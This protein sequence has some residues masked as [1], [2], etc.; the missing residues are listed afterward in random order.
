MEKVFEIYIRTTPERL[1][2]AITDP[3]I[4]EQVQL[5]RRGHLGLDAGSR[6]EMATSAADVLLGEGENLEVDPPRRLVQTMTALWSDEVKGE[7]PSR[8]TWEITQV[9]DS[10]RLTVTHDQ[11][12]EGANEQ[13]YG[14]WPMILSGLKTWL[15]TGELLTTPG[16]LMY[17]E[18]SRTGRATA[19]GRGLTFGSMSPAVVHVA[20][21]PDDEA[22]GSPG[23]LL[24][25]KDR[26]WR[27]VSVF[28]SLGLP[29]Q[30][31]RRRAEAEE[32]SRRAGFEPV[33]LDPP[34]RIS[35]HDDL[36]T[37][38]GPRGGRAAPDRRRPRRN[39]RRVTLSPRG[40]P[41]PRN[42][43]PGRA[44]GHG[45]AAPV[46]PLVDVGRV[47]R[48]PRTQRLLPLRRAR[49][50]SHAAHPGG[51][52]RRARAQRLPA[53]AHRSVRLQCGA[54]I[55]TRLR[56]RVA[57]RQRPPLR[58]GAH[59]GAPRRRPLDGLRSRTSSTRAR[60]PRN[61]S[62]SDLTAWI[63]SPSAARL[64]VS[65]GEVPRGPTPEGSGVPT[66]AGGGGVPAAGCRR[67]A[68]PGRDGGNADPRAAGDGAVPGSRSWTDHRG[69]RVTEGVVTS[70]SPMRR[71]AYSRVSGSAIPGRKILARWLFSTVG[72][73]AP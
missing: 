22:L 53:T 42:G 44:T 58:R 60:C 4:T 20:P 51:L 35:R 3:E 16:S 46:R 29:D 9:Q 37:G 6:L 49:P 69:S 39:A 41:R 55:R 11:L 12:R 14:G 38:R 33:F 23:A 61:I 71:L 30:W 47:G 17:G 68:P 67:P 27:V 13:L 7:G 72:A 32:A 59:R 26:G 73:R 36:A 1:W 66:M 43:G 70:S 45:S 50:G 25:L 19:V 24:H 62:A 28:A 31:E 57:G 40:A 54:G 5:R 21:H 63:E 56:V 52:R 65:G 64:S 48:P 34:L 10:C 18:L 8:V 2:E 15:E